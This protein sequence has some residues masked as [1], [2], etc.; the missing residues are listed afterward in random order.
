MPEPLR[1]RQGAPGLLEA[2]G[3]T[4]IQLTALIHIILCLRFS[5]PTA[6]PPG[7]CTSQIKGND[8]NNSYYTIR[9][10][11]EVVWENIED[12]YISIYLRVHLHLNKIINLILH[13]KRSQMQTVYW[14]Q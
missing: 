3:S 4:V 8:T 6:S 7:P 14:T 1:T 11:V 13:Q 9:D 5:F 10:R 12:N 2:V